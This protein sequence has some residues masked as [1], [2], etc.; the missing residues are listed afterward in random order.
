MK[1]SLLLIFSSVFALT[2]TGCN[3]FHNV[4]PI[5]GNVVAIEIDGK[6]K[7][8]KYNFDD[9]FW[10]IAGLNFTSHHS[11]TG[12]EVDSPEFFAKIG[13]HDYATDRADSRLGAYSTLLPW[14][15]ESEWKK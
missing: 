6:L 9:N 14:E 1:K 7:Q 2:L 3:A 8:T 5:I 12:F 11:L 10:N 4:K 15:F 13:V